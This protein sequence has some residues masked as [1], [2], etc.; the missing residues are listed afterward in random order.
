MSLWQKNTF[1]LIWRNGIPTDDLNI[2]YYCESHEVL[3]CC[4]KKP[5]LSKWLRICQF[6]YFQKHETAKNK[7]ESYFLNSANTLSFILLSPYQYDTSSIIVLFNLT[8]A[9]LFNGSEISRLNWNSC[10]VFSCQQYKGT[11]KFLNTLFDRLLNKNKIVPQYRQ[12]KVGVV[13][14]PKL[15]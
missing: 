2:R 1:I 15:K 3:C 5:C 4:H 13:S 11:S 9:I 14:L 6:N 10:Q 8:I 12:R 7:L